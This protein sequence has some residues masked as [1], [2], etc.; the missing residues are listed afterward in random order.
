MLA[1]VGQH[2]NTDILGL[3]QAYKASPDDVDYQGNGLI[4]LAA[5]YKNN[6]LLSYLIER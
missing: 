2:Q 4:H 5:M 3:F 6:K 1:V